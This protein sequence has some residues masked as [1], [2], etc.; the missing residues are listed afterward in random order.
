MEPQDS[1][2]QAK[3]GDSAIWIHLPESIEEGTGGPLSGLTFAVK[4][5]IDV[6]GM[7]TTA[8]CP[9]FSYSP[10]TDASVVSALRA[11]GAVPVGKTNLDQFATGLVGVRSPYGTPENPYDAAYIPGGSSSGSAVAVARGQVDFSL[12]TDTAGSGRVPAAYN[13][14][15]GLKPSRGLLS[16]LGVVPACKSLDCVS[17]FTRTVELA[18]DVFAEVKQGDRKDPWCRTDRLQKHPL[19]PPRVG[20]P[21]RDQLD[22][23]RMP[24]YAGL[25]DAAVERMRRLGWLPVEIDLTP[26]LET[27]QLLYGGPWV[28][29]RTAAIASFLQEQPEALHPVTRGII[30]GG[31]QQT[32]VQTFNST[33][34]LRELQHRVATSWKEI[35]LLL[36]PTA[37]AHYTLS[38]VEADPVATNS[39]VGLYTNWMNLLDLCAVAIPAGFTEQGLPFGITL[40]APALHD[41]YLLNLAEGF[42]EEKHP[43]R[44][45]APGWISV[46]V[47]GAHLE[48]YPLNG[49]LTERGAV[50][51]KR[52]KSAPCYK[53]YALPGKVL[54]PGM[55]RVPEGGAVIDLEIW[56]LPV[57]Q[58]GS[59]VELIP[60]PLGMG[61]VLLE[62]GTQVKGFVCEAIAA[63]EAEDITSLGSWRAFA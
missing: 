2:K 33:Y 15:V 14:L 13:N 34:R 30:E 60:A 58:F 37:P 16:T 63:Q 59:F 61:T 19:N 43:D 24:A 42:L 62:D 18:R 53:F 32:A 39:H 54:K 38:E 23:S 4:D 47:C 9:S 17:I 31:F 57:D 48:G 44:G 20:V 7:P 51:R 6:A 25:F 3:A 10:E 12:G 26:F 1:L 46:A 45:T 5:N 22:F 29:E 28:A 40:Q 52:V 50:L 55:V 35:D 41:D 8:A 56:D 27:A 11:A 36:T 21:R 49:Q